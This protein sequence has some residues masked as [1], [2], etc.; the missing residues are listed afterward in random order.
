MQSLLRDYWRSRLGAIFAGFGAVAPFGPVPLALNCIGG[1]TFQNLNQILPGQGSLEQ[2][3]VSLRAGH[4]L[5]L[6][7]D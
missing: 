4:F 7:A 1:L 5:P 2:R 3:R 6:L